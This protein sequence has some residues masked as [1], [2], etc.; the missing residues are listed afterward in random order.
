[1]ERHNRQSKAYFLFFSGLSLFFLL[2][3]ATSLLHSVRVLISYAV[4]PT[5]DFGERTRYYFRNVPENILNI[6]KAYRNNWKL[7][8]EIKEKEIVF[9]KAK[10]ALAENERLTELLGFKRRL[11]WKGEWSRIIGKSYH[12]WHSSAFLDKGSRSGV[13][14]GFPVIAMSESGVVFAGRVFEVYP[15]YSKVTLV[16]NEN[17]SYICTL[18]AGGPDALVEGTGGRT[19]LLSRAPPGYAIKEGEEIYTSPASV[20]APAGILFGTV[21]GVRRSDDYEFSSVADVLSAFD[22]WKTREVFVIYSDRGRKFAEE[23]GTR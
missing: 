21:A 22:V 15:E 11:D 20:I 10:A 13:K 23:G 5:L 18:G 8:D 14:A 3:P 9:L 12:N 17:S 1:M 16:T 2:L 6:L 7:K 19:L 4:N